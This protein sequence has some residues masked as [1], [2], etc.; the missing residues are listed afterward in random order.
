MTQSQ[1][2]WE[3][4]GG[5]RE[6][7]REEREGGPPSSALEASGGGKLLLGKGEKPEL[8]AGLG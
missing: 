1:A 2:G 7:L 6:V 4:V 3:S 5:A 8:M